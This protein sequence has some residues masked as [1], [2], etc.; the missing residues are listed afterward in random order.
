MLR[1]VGCVMFVLMFGAAD[2]A[3]RNKELGWFILYVALASG[4]LWLIT[5]PPLELSATFHEEGERV[6]SG[7]SGDAK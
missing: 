2:V 6:S 5:G 7:A 3:A 1:F 4:V